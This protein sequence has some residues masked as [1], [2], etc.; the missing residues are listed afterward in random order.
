MKFR[1]ADLGSLPTFGTLV[2]GAGR[3][4]SRGYGRRV[5]IVFDGSAPDVTFRS[6]GIERVER[7]GRVLSV[8]SSGGAERVVEEARALGPVAVDVLPVTLKEIFLE[9]VVTES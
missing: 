5:Q 1:S 3:L 8:L 7:N 4:G 9:S 2:K 6:P